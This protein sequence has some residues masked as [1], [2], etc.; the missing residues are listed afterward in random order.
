MDSHGQM[1]RYTL[2]QDGGPPGYS[3]LFS[4]TPK[5]EKMVVKIMEIPIEK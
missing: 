5:K 3:Q 2:W 1:A 4:A